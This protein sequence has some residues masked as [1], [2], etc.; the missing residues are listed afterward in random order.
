MIG[1]VLGELWGMIDQ[2]AL[3]PTNP[4]TR[5]KRLKN[6]S[7]QNLDMGSASCPRRQVAATLLDCTCT[8]RASMMACRASANRSATASEST[9]FCASRPA[10]DSPTAPRAPRPEDSTLSSV[11]PCALGTKLLP[12]A[13]APDSPAY[14]TA[15]DRPTYTQSSDYRESL[16]NLLPERLIS[17]RRALRN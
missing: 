9:I 17:K 11:E 10:L 16:A 5:S 3:G 15:S 6:A 13:V 12:W 4:T 14:R 7:C 2:V 1:E 8:F